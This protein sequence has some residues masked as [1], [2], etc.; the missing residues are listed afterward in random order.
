MEVSG[1][2]DGLAEIVGELI[3]KELFVSAANCAN[4]VFKSAFSNNTVT[5][6]S[7]TGSKVSVC[8]GNFFP[9]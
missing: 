2:H 6:F 3:G 4:V 8:T 9:C 1:N 7:G 5:T